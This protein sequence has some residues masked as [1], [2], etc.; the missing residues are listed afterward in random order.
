VAREIAQRHK[1]GT[2]RA[3]GT[4]RTA[5]IVSALSEAAAKPPFVLQA[6]LGQT[7]RLEACHDCKV[8]RP[9]A[10]MRLALRAAGRVRVC[11]H[12]CFARLRAS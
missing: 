7:A 8:Q 12:G 11:R 6:S 2:G 4:L 3:P 1:L 10:A 9:L 5:N